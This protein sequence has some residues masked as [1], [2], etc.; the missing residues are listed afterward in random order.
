MWC[1]IGT[2]T[3]NCIRS[4]PADRSWPQYSLYPHTT[5]SI[6]NILSNCVCDSWNV[7]SLKLS[8]NFCHVLSVIFRYV[9][10]VVASSD[11][12]SRSF[13][14]ILSKVALFSTKLKPNYHCLNCA[15]LQDTTQWIYT[16]LPLF[17]SFSGNQRSISVY[18]HRGKRVKPT[19]PHCFLLEVCRCFPL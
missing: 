19:I 18:V 5:C 6:V 16:K 12:T 14:Y 8:A 7:P 11:F 9:S 15:I 4:L 1:P 13:D 3:Q 10:T 17:I 2:S